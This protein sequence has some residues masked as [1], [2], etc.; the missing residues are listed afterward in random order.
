[1][2]VC[3]HITRELF[4]RPAISNVTVNVNYVHVCAV[5]KSNECF[6]FFSSVLREVCLLAEKPTQA[7][8]R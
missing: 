1:M 5:C 4:L 8:G 3:P 7:S 2:S 6:W